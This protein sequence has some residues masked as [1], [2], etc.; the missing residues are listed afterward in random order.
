MPS[1]PRLLMVYPMPLEVGAGAEVNFLAMAETFRELGAKLVV[2]SFDWGLS[3][4]RLLPTETIR[5]VFGNV[6][7]IKIPAR[8]FLGLPVPLP[9]LDGLK[10]LSRLVKWADI[11]LFNQYY[12]S[13]VLLQLLSRMHGRRTL[14][15]AGTLAHQDSGSLKEL[16]QDTYFETLGMWALN[17]SLSIRVPSD[18]LG[19][20][21]VSHRVMVPLHVIPPPG[22][23]LTSTLL[24]G[25]ARPQA[26]LSR[27]NS[28]R[29]GLVV[30]VAG[31]MGRQKGIDT[32]AEVI[33]GIRR[34]SAPVRYTFCFAGTDELP[35]PIRSLP[36]EVLRSVRNL[37]RLSHDD[38]MDAMRSSD[39]LF[40]PSRYEGFSVAA[41]EALAVGC[42]LVSSDV[43]G[44][45][46]IIEAERTG[47]IVQRD[48]VR[49]FIDALKRCQE[50]KTSSPDRWALM[51]SESIKRFDD[52]FSSEHYKTRVSAWLASGCKVPGPQD[53]VSRHLR[54]PRRDN[55]SQGHDNTL[56]RSLLILSPTSLRCG[57]GGEVDL[58]ETAGTLRDFGVK[59]S[60]LHVD[61]V[62]KGVERISESTIQERLSG[63]SVELLPSVGL[64]KYRLPFPSL[65]GLIRLS[66]EIEK[67]DATMI[68]Q[69]YGVD[70]ISLFLCM[71][72]SKPLIVSQGNAF[73]H[74]RFSPG[75][76]AQ[77][78]YNQ[79]VGLRVLLRAAGVRVW[80]KDD[81][82]FLLERGQPE[83][84]IVYPRPPQ[85][86]Q[87]A[88]RESREHPHEAR[89]PVPYSP[90]TGTAS[91]ISLPPTS[92]GGYPREPVVAEP[93]RVLVAG[94]MSPQKG[95]DVV[96]DVVSRVMDDKGSSSHNV[97]FY[98]AGSPQ[99]P[100]E[101]KGLQLPQ[102]ELVI[103]LGV[104]P[105]EKL[106]LTMGQMDLLLFPS[107][108]ESFGMVAME[109]QSQGMPV[110]CSRVTGITD[111]VEQGLTG[112]LVSGRDAK[113]YVRAIYHYAAMKRQHPEEWR[114]L[115]SRCIDTF[116]TKFSR[117]QY[118][119][120][121]RDLID[122]IEGALLRREA[123][124]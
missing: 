68:S 19:E 106:L 115:R 98:F 44:F 32:I 90:A 40:M 9:S 24:G 22:P 116:K 73:R 2:A 82:R 13:D 86:L 84:K 64:G 87:S 94:R 63:V 119:A 28:V 43:G 36:A 62:Y 31:R 34:E 51:K 26:P 111:I 39:V 85:G 67:S 118:E 65:K 49:G 27:P 52:L 108:Y 96:R 55:P 100:Q 97:I 81:L 41:L 105:R 78:I 25:R 4:P 83:A 75:E 66:K 23:D 101:M 21:L 120:S 60:L 50:M 17:R 123:N 102:E 5:A 69:Y 113:E 80:N 110:L 47:F 103:N 58:I 42:P 35:G 45:K 71:L 72:K 57:A 56:S 122:G 18:Q 14:V 3:S 95:I 11:V 74:S 12:I 114:Q 38:L 124:G 77:D 29:E 54:D 76:A 93:F 15:N 70:L 92:V 33:Q 46:E 6:A 121:V 7:W 53:C 16:L 104:L 91:S 89:Y 30:L 112:T 88:Q 117:E 1:R 61:F 59:V 8:K 107:H 79:V 37:G 10:T 109:A 48:D 20:W 99:V